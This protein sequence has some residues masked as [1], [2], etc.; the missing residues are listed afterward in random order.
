[1]P[2]EVGLSVAHERNSKKG[3]HERFV[4][5]SMNFRLAKSLS[6]L[7]GAD[8]YIHNGR[9]SRVFAELRNLF[10]RSSP[11]PAIQEMWLI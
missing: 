8:P 4:C 5:E 6:D 1:M 10:V 11:L 3:K 9:I 7:N 2:F